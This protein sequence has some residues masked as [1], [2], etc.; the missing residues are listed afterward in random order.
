MDT[1]PDS[2]NLGS[3]PPLAK[4]L[5]QS[6]RVE[7]KVEHCALDLSSV[8][9]I[10]KE[11]VKEDIPEH[12]PAKEISKALAQSKRIEDKVQECAKELHLVNASLA[13]EIVEREGL[14]KEL[15]DCKASERHNRYLAYHDAATGLA[16]RALFNDRLGH[17]LAQAERHSW[18]L[19]LMFID[20]D[21]FKAINDTYGH[22]TGGRVLKSVS[23]ALPL[24]AREEDAVSRVGGDEFL[25]LLMETGEDEAVSRIARLMI[26]RTA[27]AC[28]FEAGRIPVKPSIGTAVY[29]RNGTSAEILVK[30]ADLAMYEAKAK[31]EGYWFF[32][33]NHQTQ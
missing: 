13:E 28:V 1:S 26:K 14:E 30:K 15:N 5:N 22:E 9:S 6:K 25:C 7:E 4:V 11:G 32:R 27:Q 17:A 31:R 2:D 16:N 18:P 33:E 20:I 19:T 10:L 29:P 12:S 21:E 23:H 8:H 24:C 3:E